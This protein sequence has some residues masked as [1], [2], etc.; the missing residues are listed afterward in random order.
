MQNSVDALKNKPDN[1]VQWNLTI[2]I[3]GLGKNDIFES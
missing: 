1:K 3:T 2:S